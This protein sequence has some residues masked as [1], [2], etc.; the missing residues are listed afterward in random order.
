MFQFPYPLIKKLIFNEQLFNLSRINQLLQQRGNTVQFEKT[1]RIATYLVG[2]SFGVS[3]I[4][5]FTLTR[6]MVT[7]E[8]GTALFNE[9]VGHLTAI[10]YPAIALP[11]TLV[12]VLAVWYLMSQLKKLTGQPIDELYSDEIKEK[13]K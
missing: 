5:N 11:S 12:M 4:L 7:A 3:T 13:V 9:Q 10:S 2:A 8:A 1:L 6:H